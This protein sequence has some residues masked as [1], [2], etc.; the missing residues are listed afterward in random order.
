MFSAGIF[1]DTA[2]VVL[3]GVLSDAAPQATTSSL[4]ISVQ[5]P[6]QSLSGQPREEEAFLGVGGQDDIP[7]ELGWRAP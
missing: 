3:A 4:L 2:V 7:L 1:S 6:T 5:G